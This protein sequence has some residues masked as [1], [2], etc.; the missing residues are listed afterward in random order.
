MQ[1]QMPIMDAHSYELILVVSCIACPILESGKDGCEWK[2]IYVIQVD[3]ALV[4]MQD[5]TV[6]YIK[7]ET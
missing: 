4:R 3:R 1:L 6:P 5:S 2:M 7:T